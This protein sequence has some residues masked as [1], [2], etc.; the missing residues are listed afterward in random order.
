M[1]AS[2][3][4]RTPNPVSCTGF[5]YRLR[6]RLSNG[7]SWAH[8]FEAN[9]PYALRDGCAEAHFDH[10]QYAESV[11]LAHAP[12]QS[13]DWERAR[14]KIMRAPIYM[15]VQHRGQWLNANYATD[16]ERMLVVRAPGTAASGE[17]WADADWADAWMRCVRC[18]S[19]ADA[20]DSFCGNIADNPGA[21]L[22]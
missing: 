19:A 13:R 20:L 18:K 16:S 3:I 9:G 22:P 15:H 6:I 5:G 10:L 21:K 7:F 14:A 11:A 8:E 2:T 1:S 12:H 4:N 17:V